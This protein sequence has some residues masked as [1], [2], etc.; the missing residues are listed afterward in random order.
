MSDYGVPMKLN[1]DVTEKFFNTNL[2]PYLNYRCFKVDSCEVEVGSVSSHP[3]VL[4]LRISLRGDCDIEGG[5]E[6]SF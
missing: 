4:R 1:S 2:D 3:E 6:E 5:K